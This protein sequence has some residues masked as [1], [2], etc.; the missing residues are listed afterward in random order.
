[1][2]ILPEHMLR[3][4]DP[5]DRACLGKAGLTKAE[6]L[7]RA[8]IRIEKDLRNQIESWLR[9]QGVE[10]IRART[11]KRSTINVGAPDLIFAWAGLPI[12]FEVKMPGEKLDPDQVV[13]REAM[14]HDGWYWFTVHSLDQAKEAL[15]AVFVPFHE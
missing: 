15:A 4:V 13:M 1:M 14:I 11:D 9:L 6:L 12:A 3:L 2:K 8:V 7:E 10:V 5:H